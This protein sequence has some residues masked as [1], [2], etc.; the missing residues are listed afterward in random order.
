M[1]YPVPT[2]VN[3]YTKQL[4]TV[5]FLSK[6][7]MTPHKNTVMCSVQ[8]CPPPIRFRSPKYPPITSKSSVSPILSMY[9]PFNLI[10]LFYA[11]SFGL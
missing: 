5:S 11:L 4:L 2:F 1:E 3:G 9:S 10:Q 8:S 7:L 6:C